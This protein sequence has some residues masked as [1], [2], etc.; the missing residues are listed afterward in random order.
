M[1]AFSYSAFNVMRRPVEVDP[2]VSTFPAESHR[3]LYGLVAEVWYVSGFM[4]ACVS[5]V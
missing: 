3:H 1:Y 4:C 5:R 2:I